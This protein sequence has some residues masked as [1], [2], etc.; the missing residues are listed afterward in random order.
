MQILESELERKCTVEAE[1]HECLLVKMQKK[2]GWPD[3][4][5]LCPNGQMAWIEFKREGEKTRKYQ[6]YIHQVLRK[7]NFRVY[8]VD[9][10]SQFQTLLRF[11]MDL[12]RPNGSPSTTKSVV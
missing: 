12:G 5:L 6:E 3:R 10:F 1:K 8:V 2:M 4:I 7:M 9:T 11:L